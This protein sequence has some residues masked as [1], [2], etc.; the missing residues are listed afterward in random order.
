M[1]VLHVEDGIVHRPAFHEVE[2]ERRGLID[3]V[4]KRQQPSRVG[5]H[6]VDDR[7]ELDEVP[8]ALGHAG[9]D[10]VDELAEPYL[11]PVALDAQS[12]DTG[13]QAGN[14]TVV[15]GAEYVDHPI[16]PANQELVTVVREVACEIGEIAVAPDQNAVAAVAELGGAEPDRPVRLVRRAPVR[17]ISRSSRQPARSPRSRPASTTRRNGCRAGRESPVC[18]RGSPRSRTGR[19]RRCPRDPRTSCASWVTYSP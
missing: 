13:H 19:P 3:R 7:V 12:R 4:E 6:L 8:G 9:T 11:Q 18:S 1:C 2:V 17:G 10:E 14:L 15:V 5:S 16:E